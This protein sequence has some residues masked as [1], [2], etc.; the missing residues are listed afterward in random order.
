MGTDASYPCRQPRGKRGWRRRGVFHCSESRLLWLVWLPLFFTAHLIYTALAVGLRGEHL[1][2]YL[3]ALFLCLWGEGTRRFLKVA[4]P[5]WV[6]GSFYDSLR[7]VPESWKPEIH[8]A[9]L[10]LAEK[11]LFGFT[12]G[13]ETRI[14]SEFF[15]T[16]TAAFLDF[17]CG[18]LYLTYLLAFFLFLLYLFFKN[19]GEAVRLGWSF[20]ILNIAG[21]VVFQLFPAA[22]PWY[23]AAYGLGPAD[24]ATPP[25]PAGLLRFDALL[26]APVSESIYKKSPEVFGAVPSLH[27]ANP[28]LMYLYGRRLGPGWAWVCLLYAASVAFSA[29]YL[30]HHYVLDIAAASA[31]A[32]AVYLVCPW[33]IERLRRG[34]RE[35]AAD[36]EPALG[37]AFSARRAD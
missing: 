30:N 28:V 35:T 36:L 6:F 12:S 29:V 23:V 2:F 19:D 37:E 18:L 9:D 24:P 15:S 27:V 22:P 7:L 25:H 31:L 5:V 3:L 16:H 17:L 26:G 4:F 11:R 20:C 10:Y 8:V 32:T 33:G 14:P 13:G 1:F 34:G 21:L